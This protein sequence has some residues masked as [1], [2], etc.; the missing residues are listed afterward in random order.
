MHG[1]DS[2]STGRMSILKP[3]ALVVSLILCS[4][5]IAP[6]PLPVHA[7]E[8]DTRETLVSGVQPGPPLWKV[9]NGEH[10]LWIFPLGAV[11]PRDII[12]V[13]DEVAAIIGA[14]DEAIGMPDISV[15]VSRTLLL[16]PINIV[17]G[18]DL[19]ERLRR[20]PDDASLADVLPAD[21]YQRYAA[22]KAA[23]FPDNRD[24]DTL[25]PNFAAEVIAEK[26]FAKERMS[27]FDVITRNVEEL[28]RRDR[29][30]R[31]TEIKV[32]RI[33]EGSYDELSGRIESVMASQSLES[34]IACFDMQLTRFEKHL[35][36]IKNEANAWATGDVRDIEDSIETGSVED[37]CAAWLLTSSEGDLAAGLWEDSMQRWFDAAVAALERNRSTFTMLPILYIK[38]S[39]SLVDRLAALGYEVHEPM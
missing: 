34:E 7:Q 11:L 38:G 26:V 39:V 31:L 4:A 20:N 32:E 19:Y 9:S 12:W 21:I 30:I 3:R 5:P 17:R 1:I 18:F 25:R 27:D 24:V 22:L 6:S 28:I 14:A 35:N 16:N 33:L 37:S 29:D 15:G 23:Y 10:E 36:D 13:N 2:E 8:N